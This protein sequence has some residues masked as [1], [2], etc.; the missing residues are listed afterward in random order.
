MISASD[1]AEMFE[2]NNDLTNTNLGFELKVMKIRHR[3]ETEQRNYDNKNLPS[4]CIFR[5]YDWSSMYEE[6]LYCDDTN[7][8][9]NLRKNLKKVCT[10]HIHTK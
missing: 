8:I 3:I 1:M 9:S 10:C 7:Y 5:E 2:E 6:D 4:K